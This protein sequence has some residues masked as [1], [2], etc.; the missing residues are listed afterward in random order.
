[1]ISHIALSIFRRFISVGRF[2][3]RVP[4]RKVAI[5]KGGEAGPTVGIRLLRRRHL[6]KI[7]YKPDLAFGELYADG[8]LIIEKGSLEDLLRLLVLNSASWRHHPAGGLGFFLF[9][10]FSRLRTMNPMARAKRNVAHHYDLGNELFASF[11]DP[12]RQYSC[13]YF[14]SGRETL[15]AAQ[16]IK[17]ARIIAKLNLKPNCSILDIGCGWGDLCLALERCEP[18][19]RVV[20]ITL[21]EQQRRHFNEL[22]AVG[23]LSKNIKCRLQD[24]RAVAERFDRIVSVGMLEHVGPQFYKKFFTS[25]DKNLAADGVALVHCIGRFHGEEALN[26]WIDK[27]IFPGAYIPTLNQVIGEIEKTNLKITDI[28]IIRLHY[29]ETL[30]HW[31]KNFIKNKHRLPAAYDEKFTRMWEFYLVGCEYFFR[32]GAAMV[33]QIQLCHKQNA[34]PLNRE[35]IRRKT[36]VYKKVVAGPWI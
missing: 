15:A 25:I 34:V 16:V 28:E 18:N 9:N 33:F 31:R 12:R 4:N 21:S 17:L 30:K 6:L 36:D 7:A 14:N 22:I 19:V 35:Y 11:L 26:R 27:Y 24:F 29:A 2:E 3:I 8:E 1:M 13:A 20:G 5:I 32:S 23:G 10:I